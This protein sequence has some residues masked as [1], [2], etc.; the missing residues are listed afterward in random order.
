MRSKRRGIVLLL[1]AG[2]S[3]MLSAS[4]VARHTDEVNAQLGPLK[5][6]LLAGRDLPRGTV[7]TAANSNRFLETRLVAERFVPRE[8]YSSPVQVMGM[9][10]KVEIPSGT[11]INSG[12]L[13]I[14]RQAPAPEAE[15][16]QRLVEIPVAGSRE[17]AGM[18]GPGSYVDLLITV[19][20]GDGSSLTYLA[21][22]DLPVV[23]QVRSNEYGDA[24]KLGGDDESGRMAVTLRVSVRTAVHLTAAE[25]F[26]KQI[27]ALPRPPG[28][29]S[30]AG[31]INVSKLTL[32]P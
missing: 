14:G 31:R 25:N 28:D 6:V 10:A 8:S 2:S 24:G 17:L 26:A 20:R 29:R 11:Y 16:G 19:E 1:L 4:L 3:A 21:Y 30:R 23:A 22:E 9:T 5:E 27:R 12:Q 32:K 18:I 7:L 15:A 13:S